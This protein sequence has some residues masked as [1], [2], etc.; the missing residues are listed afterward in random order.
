[1]VILLQLFGIL[2]MVAVVGFVINLLIGGTVFI[3]TKPLEDE[4]DRR[5]NV[6]LQNWGNSV[7]KYHINLSAPIVCLILDNTYIPFHV[8]RQGQQLLLFE[9]KP[10][11][12]AFLNREN[13]YLEADELLPYGLEVK[14]IYRVWQQNYERT[15]VEYNGG[16][17]E[18]RIEDFQI[19]AAIFPEFC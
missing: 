19:L 18:F 6:G 3:A 10:T 8:W 17:Y 14:R 13:R 1:M 2:I 9:T 15:A 4:K 7:N 16:T 11:R 5:Y 12:E